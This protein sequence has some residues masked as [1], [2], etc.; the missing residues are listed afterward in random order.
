MQSKAYILENRAGALANYP[1]AREVDGLIFISGISSRRPDNTH[2][3][4]VIHED[5]RVEKDIREQTRAVIGNIGA[6]ITRSSQPWR[7]TFSS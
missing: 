4:V 2:V 7:R 5:G 6:V 1:H 3:G